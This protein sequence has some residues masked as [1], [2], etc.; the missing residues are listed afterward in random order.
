MRIFIGP[1]EIAGIGHGLREGLVSLGHHCDLIIATPHRFSYGAEAGSSRLVRIWQ[2]VNGQIRNSSKGRLQKLPWYL[3]RAVLRWA[4]VARCLN[5]YDA[6]IF[7][8][9]LTITNSELELWLL[10]AFRK[11]IAFWYVGSDARPPYMSGGK[12]QPPFSADVGERLYVET[13]KVSQLLALHEKYADSIITSPTI[14]QFNKRRLLNWFAIGIPRDI[15]EYKGPDI[16]AGNKKVV[17]A[18]HSPSKPLVK[19]TALIKKA[20]ENL[21]AKGVAIELVLLEGMPN[22]VVLEEI[23][24]ADFVIDQAYSDQPLATFATEAAHFGKPA[25]V[26]GYFAEV[27]GSYLEPAFVGPSEFVTPDKIEQAVEKLATDES[28]RIK[29]GQRAKT[30]VDSNWTAQ[31]VAE[32]FLTVLSGKAPDHWY[33][34]P[35]G[36]TYV[37]GCG[38]SRESTAA[39]VG[40]LVRDYGPSALLVDDKPELKTALISLAAAFDHLWHDSR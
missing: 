4:L 3:A 5:D 30:Y 36:T 40:A 9:G 32:R 18:L 35:N 19:G 22:S 17:R 33:F 26:G 24:R 10:K 27:V 16:V 14:A 29:L 7:I 31:A 15:P 38:L 28:Y 21:N 23:S 39:L 6:F 25:V 11:K 2:W 1:T 13:K 34:D 37:E 20:V 12:F 8:S